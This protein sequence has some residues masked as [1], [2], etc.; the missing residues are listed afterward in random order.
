M[1]VVDRYSAGTE[2]S[3]DESADLGL[4]FRN[5]HSLF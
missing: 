3:V 4:S 5:S 1:S 2:H